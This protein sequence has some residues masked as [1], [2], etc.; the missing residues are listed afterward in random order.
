MHNFTV[1]V[2]ASKAIPPDT[3]ESHDGN[4]Y[5]STYNTLAD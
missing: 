4:T 2:H 1:D 5:F 3:Y